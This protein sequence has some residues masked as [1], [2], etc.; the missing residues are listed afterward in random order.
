MWCQCVYWGDD[1]VGGRGFQQTFRI[2]VS[3]ADGRAKNVH[4]SSALLRTPGRVCV[5]TLFI[6]LWVGFV[7]FSTV[8]KRIGLHMMN[9]VTIYYLK[10]Q[11]KC[12]CI[13]F[14]WTRKVA[15][16]SHCIV[17]VFVACLMMEPSLYPF[18]KPFLFWWDCM[19]Q[20]GPFCFC[21]FHYETV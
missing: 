15:D 7:K 1:I 16:H 6:M 18:Q 20:N 5:G 21:T 12:Q 14:Y 3:H 2:C 11:F 4:W 8:L 13:L 9:D 17:C 10:C 19:N